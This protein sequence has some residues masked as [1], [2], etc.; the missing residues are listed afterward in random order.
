[1]APRP[2][3]LP[4][5][6]QSEPAPPE[7]PPADGHAEM[8]TEY[9]LG[10]EA[11]ERAQL[12]AFGRRIQELQKQVSTE[13]GQPIQRGFH[14]KSHAC[15]SGTFEL[16]PHRDPRSRFGLFADGAPNRRITVRFSNGVGWKQDDGELD[17]RGLAVKV[18]DVPGPKYLP[19]EPTTQDFLM[20]NAPTPVGRDAVEF[21]EF[22][23]ANVRGQLFSF[24]FM[25]THPTTA[26]PALAR[27][28]PI[29]SMVTQQYWSGGAYH[30][31]AHQAVKFSARPCDLRLSREPEKGSPDYLRKDLE[32]AAREGLCMRFLVQFQSDPE[33]TPI[34][35]ASKAWSESDA[36]FVTVGRLVLPPQTVDAGATSACDA[37]AFS[38]WHALPAHKPM[39]HIN[40]ARRYVYRASQEARHAVP[41]V[42]PKTE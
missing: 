23:K 29:E 3:R 21:M 7:L 36:P 37:M 34:E 4:V 16:D 25:A 38:P 24:F 14:A 41:T 20:T 11:E 17:A 19:D 15:L 35:N 39:G 30:L 8:N 31:G 12:A 26:A 2:A 28:V 42:S 18:F 6:P 22:A 40:R 13:R 9:F 1:M 27:T 10:S 5:D 33:K 32:A